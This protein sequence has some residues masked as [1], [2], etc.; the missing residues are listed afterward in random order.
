V[1]STQ[2]DASRDRGVAFELYVQFRNVSG[3]CNAILTDDM[4]GPSTPPGNL[5]FSQKVHT[6]FDVHSRASLGTLERYRSFRLPR[7]QNR[8]HRG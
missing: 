8:A 3:I 7:L 6:K 4:P 1:V 5:G 2:V